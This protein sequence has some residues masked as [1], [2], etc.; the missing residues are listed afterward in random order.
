MDNCH[1]LGQSNSPSLYYFS[2]EFHFEIQ[3][4]PFSL[5]V[6]RTV[7]YE[8][9]AVGMQYSTQWREKQRKTACTERMKKQRKAD[10]SSE[11]QDTFLVAFQ[12]VQR[13]RC[14]PV[15]KHLILC[16]KAV[17]N[18]FSPPLH[19]SLSS[20]TLEAKRVRHDIKCLLDRR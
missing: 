3:K 20:L 11:K 12:S 15:L 16:W 19:V 18:P 4:Q 14:I 6:A 13:P 9:R 8:F 1:K 5:H 10:P 17:I 7:T 2:P